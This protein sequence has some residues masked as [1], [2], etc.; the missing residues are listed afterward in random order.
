[1]SEKT[2]ETRE[3]NVFH[4]EDFCPACL[5][6]KALMERRTRYSDFFDHIHNARIEMLRAFKSLVDAEIASLE[7]RKA[8][9]EEEKRA[10]RIE[11][12]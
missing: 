12:E 10:T 5:F 11:V 4:P 2:E 9:H 3:Q 1:M 6:I 8:G 7:K